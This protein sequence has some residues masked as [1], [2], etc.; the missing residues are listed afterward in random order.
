[1]NTIVN[2]A[3]LAR[4]SGYSHGI[5]VEPGRGLLALAGQV[6]WDR[7]NRI[8]SD[9]F[10]EQ[11]EQ[12][13]ANLLAVVAAAG[14]APESV[15]K[16][17]LFVTNKGEYIASVKNVGERYRRLMGTHYPAMTLVEVKALLEAG[18]KIEIEGLAAI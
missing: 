10:A 14:G 12:A 18:A 16:L 8:V 13:L 3:S 5:R 9:D 1:L 15:V 7:N 11:F 2:P 17:T 4:P 6:A